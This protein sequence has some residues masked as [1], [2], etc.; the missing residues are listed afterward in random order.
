MKYTKVLVMYILHVGYGQYDNDF[1]RLSVSADKATFTTDLKSVTCITCLV[2]N[3]SL[4]S[5]VLKVTLDSYRESLNRSP[6]LLLVQSS[7]TPDL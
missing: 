6:R 4:F 3:C 1:C 7:Q 2:T 5:A